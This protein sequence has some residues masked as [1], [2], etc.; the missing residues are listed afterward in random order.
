PVTARTARARCT[1]CGPPN[2]RTARSAP[3]GTSPGPPCSWPATRRDT[4][5]ASRSW[6]TAA[7]PCAP[8][9]AATGRR[10][11]RT[12]SCLG[13][14]ASPHFAVAVLDKTIWD[15][16]CPRVLLLLGFAITGNN[17]TKIRHCEERSDVAIQGGGDRLWDADD[18]TRSSQRS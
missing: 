18:R 15:A 9:R 5:T 4:S 16:I 14:D 3:A 13:I 10:R 6:S 11:S 1:T 12:E 2:A 7:S 8:P 17:T